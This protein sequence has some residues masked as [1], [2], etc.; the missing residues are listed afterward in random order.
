MVQEI[1]KF[2]KEAKER[3]KNKDRPDFFKK[4]GKYAFYA[5]ILISGG[6]AIASGV[7]APAWVLIVLGVLDSMAATTIANT[8]L[9]N[10]DKPQELEGK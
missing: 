8:F 5:S 10:K 1:K 9:P 2:T 6:I 7:G 3:V 4:L